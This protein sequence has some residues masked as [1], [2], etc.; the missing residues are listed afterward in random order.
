MRPL[1]L[2][3]LLTAP[4]MANAYTWTQTIDFNPDPVLTTGTT[5]TFT[6]DLKTAGFNPGADSVSDYNLT[7]SLINTAGILDVL[8]IDQPGV[9]GDT[10]ALF[11]NWSAVSLTTSDSYQGVASL[12]N[13]GLLSIS[14][15]SL[16]GT[17]SLDKSA[18][19]ATGSQAT[20]SQPGTVSSVP[21]PTSVALLAAGLFGIALMRRNNKEQDSN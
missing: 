16:L 21:E 12:N 6:H 13:N 1:I 3:I 17:F 7:L 5:Y 15:T 4:L 14:I 8:Y 19:S 20:G 11:Y 10:A 2:G 18:L 9:S